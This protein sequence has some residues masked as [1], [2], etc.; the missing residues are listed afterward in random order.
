MAGSELSA[1]NR[2]TQRPLCFLST[3]SSITP[4]ISATT[5][6]SVQGRTSQTGGEQ[7]VTSLKKKK[8]Q[9]QGK[10][11]EHVTPPSVE[12]GNSLEMEE[13]LSCCQLGLTFLSAWLLLD[14]RVSVL[15]CSS[16]WQLLPISNQWPRGGM[17]T[18]ILGQ[19]GQELIAPITE[20][21]SLQALI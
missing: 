12:R 9:T 8:K 15:L 17:R 20:Y 2:Q 7:L 3:L 16:A 11:R 4:S 1:K 14:P 6:T 5:S 19:M 13:G 18:L 21:L 10:E